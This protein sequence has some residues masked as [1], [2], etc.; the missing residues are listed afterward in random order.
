MTT[1]ATIG[2]LNRHDPTGSAS[3]GVAEVVVVPF[4]R[5]EITLRIDPNTKRVEVLQVR[6]KT[7][8]RTSEQKLASARYIDV[9]DF[10]KD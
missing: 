6:V 10:Y 1:T 9:D 2:S 3:A 4:D 7:D 5:Y 8:F